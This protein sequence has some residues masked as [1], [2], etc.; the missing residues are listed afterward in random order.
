M[1]IRAKGE[2]QSERE[3]KEERERSGHHMSDRGLKTFTFT[4][5]KRYSETNAVTQRF[6]E[7]L[8][9]RNAQRERERER[10]RKTTEITKS[11]VFFPFSFV[12]NL[13]HCGCA[14][15]VIIEREREVGIEKRK[16]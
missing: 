13:L 16:T 10:E 7:S 12:N 6:C 3:G 4:R 15:S 5:E 11:V 9:I 8:I 14:P 1:R 2:R